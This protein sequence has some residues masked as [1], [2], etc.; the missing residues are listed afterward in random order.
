MARAS[1]IDHDS[2]LYAEIQNGTSVSISLQFFVNDGQLSDTITLVS[3]DRFERQRTFEG[4][5]SLSCNIGSDSAIPTLRYDSIKVI[6]NDTLVV[7]HYDITEAD[8]LSDSL[9]SAGIKF[10]DARN[11][12]N[13]NGYNCSQVGDES[14][15]RRY[16][17]N[18][19]DLDYAV[20]INE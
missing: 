2:S 20:S 11:V 9:Q 6:Y 16:V 4:T 15:R 17:F 13:E 3:G 7:T 19:E 10:D 1:C 18:D 8:G 12:F 5:E 14:I